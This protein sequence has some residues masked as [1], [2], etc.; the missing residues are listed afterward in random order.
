MLDRPSAQKFADVIRREIVHDAKTRHRLR[1]ADERLPMVG[2][3]AL[4][5]I[6]VL[7]EGPDNHAEPRHQAVSLRDRVQLADRA[8]LIEHKKRRKS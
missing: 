3:V 7:R 6:E 8:E 2:I 5:L 4:Q 1:I